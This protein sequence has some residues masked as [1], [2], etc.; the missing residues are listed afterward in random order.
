ML[1]VSAA[2]IELGNV[3]NNTAAES[4]STA[5]NCEV[6]ININALLIDGV[7]VL[8][9]YILLLVLILALLVAVIVVPVVCCC[10]CCKKDKRCC[11]KANETV[12]SD[13]DPT[14]EMVEVEQKDSKN[15]TKNDENKN[16]E[17]KNEETSQNTGPTKTVHVASI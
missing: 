17:N 13:Q 9:V 1:G 15:E 16:D 4:V 6:Q 7:W 5:Q 12:K 8:I 10:C 11:K 3:N 2:S 14:I